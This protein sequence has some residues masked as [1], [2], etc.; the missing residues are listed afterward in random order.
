MRASRAFLAAVALALIATA[1]LRGQATVSSSLPY[2][3]FLL[4]EG[5]PLKLEV[6]NQTGGEIVL[7]SEDVD[8]QV[9]FRVRDVDN[10][11]IP[12]TDRPLLEEP[13]V[14]PAGETAEKE[15]DL[16]QLFHIRRDRS[17]RGLQHVIVDGNAYEGPPLKFEVVRG[18]LMDEI[19]RRKSDRVFSMIGVSRN[20][21]DELM[22][23]ITDKDKVVTFGTYFLERHMRFYPPHMK[24]NEA[25]EVGTL[26]YMGPQ[27]VVLC[28]FQPDGIPIKRS[29]LQA[30]PGVPV[31]LHAHPETSFR[32][33]GAVEAGGGK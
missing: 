24:V 23:R 8:N 3:T 30:S 6:T 18:M 22:M 7:S 1:S 25:G 31:R 28:I 19:K 14:I 33:E 11:V 10:N 16:V 32:V 4:M 27:Q 5:I 21:R 9:V 17:Y 29:Y 2:R 20:G 15:F 13:W 26:H 12:R